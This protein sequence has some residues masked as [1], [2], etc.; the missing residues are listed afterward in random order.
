MGCVVGGGVLT[1]SAHSPYLLIFNDGV[2]AYSPPR[3]FPSCAEPSKF[4]NFNII[5]LKRSLKFATR[6]VQFFKW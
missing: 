6:Q 4:L 5:S 2:S 1:P 3:L